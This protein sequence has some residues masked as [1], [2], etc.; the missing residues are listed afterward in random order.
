M[1]AW[2]HYYHNVQGKWGS[3]HARHTSRSVF[4][5][6]LEQLPTVSF[7]LIIMVKWLYSIHLYMHLH[8][9][10]PCWIYSFT[11]KL[12]PAVVGKVESEK[13]EKGTETTKESLTPVQAK[14][15]SEWVPLEL[16][17]G[18]PLFNESAN[19]AVCDRVS[20]YIN[21]QVCLIYKIECKCN[22]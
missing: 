11:E 13:S 19:A 10:I 20:L 17:F 2:G 18:I 16:S 22:L 15:K 3:A 4:V 6:D 7:Y 9:I 21:V 14:L 12:P 1:Y 8:I 5:S